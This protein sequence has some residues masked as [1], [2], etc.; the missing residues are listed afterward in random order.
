MNPVILFLKLNLTIM[1]TVYLSFEVIGHSKNFYNL[2][3]NNGKEGISAISF[4]SG[5]LVN[6]KTGS[7]VRRNQDGYIQLGESFQGF[8]FVNTKG[9]E[10]VRPVQTTPPAELQEVSR[11]VIKN[12]GKYSTDKVRRVEAALRSNYSTP[13]ELANALTVSSG[14]RLYNIEG[15]DFEVKREIYTPEQRTAGFAAIVAMAKAGGTVRF[16]QDDFGNVTGLSAS[17]KKFNDSTD[18][19]EASLR[20]E[21]ATRVN[22]IINCDYIFHRAENGLVYLDVKVHKTNK[23]VVFDDNVFL[24]RDGNATLV[25]KGQKIVDYIQ[26]FT[27]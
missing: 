14:E 15:Q 25:L 27:A 10:Y 21:F 5:Y 2:R 19:L 6:P 8:Y 4:L 16:G 1:A 18:K 23:P 7:P 12:I 24:R 13:K 26:S 9:V 20:G 3:D 11:R 17:L 22:T